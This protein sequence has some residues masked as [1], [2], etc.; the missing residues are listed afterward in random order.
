MKLNE[1]KFELI[2]HSYHKPNSNLILLKE[3]PFSSV[4]NEYSTGNNLIIS[5]S[6]YVRD[7]GVLVDYEL[8]WNC[9]ITNLCKIGRKLSGWVLSVFYTRDA[10]TM[11]TLFNSIVR[12]KLE[13]CSQIWD[14]FLM[15]HISAIEQIQQNFTKRIQ[16]V[17]NLDYWERME[18]LKI[19]SLQRR[20]EKLTIIYVWKIKNKHVPNDTNL[21]FL[22]N[23]RKSTSL[24]LIKP[25]PRVTG[26]LLS[27]FENSFHIKSAKLWNKLPHKLR[28]ID[29]LLTFKNQLDKYLTLIPDKPPI[30][31]YYHLN[32][33]SILDF[34]QQP[35]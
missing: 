25:M 27:M 28:Q 31:G 4:Y 2:S 16:S 17:Q 26:K 21:E 15:K 8:N 29:N 23:N 11:L 35:F 6:L 19:M 10:F 13:Y 14:P 33:N 18:K 7:L 12:S 24:A 3:L 32:K 9:H 34:N 30:R 5:P 22:L 20:R 1:D